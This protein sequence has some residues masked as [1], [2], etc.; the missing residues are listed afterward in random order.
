MSLTEKQ[1]TLGNELFTAT[2]GRTSGG[3]VFKGM[4]TADGKSLVRGGTDIFEVRLADGTQYSSADMKMSNLKS[5][6]FKAVPGSV[7]LAP[8]EPGKALTATFTAPEG[9]EKKM[10]A[11]AFKKKNG[12]VVAD[13]KVAEGP[14][15]FD[16][17]GAC[18][19]TFRYAKGSHK[20]NLVGVQLLQEGGKVV[21]EDI[22]AG[23]MFRQ[24]GRRAIPPLSDR[25]PAPMVC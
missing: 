24:S 23:T 20:L 13:L 7:Q 4:K 6:D 14:V 22:H 1:A 21:A 18:K 5:Q 3:V 8:R 2:F 10:G 15:R 9:V 12:P 17:G 19:L 11:D 16:K 25:P